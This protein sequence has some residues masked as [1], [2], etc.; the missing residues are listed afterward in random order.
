[1]FPQNQIRVDILLHGVDRPVYAETH[2]TVVY[3][4]CFDKNSH[5]HGIS[6][7]LAP[8]SQ[9]SPGALP[10]PV[11]P[12]SPHTHQLVPR[13]TLHVWLCILPHQQHFYSLFPLHSL[14]YDCQIHSPY[15]LL[16]W[17]L[18]KNSCHYVSPRHHD[19]LPLQSHPL[20]PKMHHWH[21]VHIFLQLL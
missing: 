17:S 10:Q 3:R 12:G 20:V 14:R 16:I 13:Q 6:E 1:M 7:H 5:P 8:A 18:V 15:H 9:K 21:V 11:A 2:G 4:D 19:Y